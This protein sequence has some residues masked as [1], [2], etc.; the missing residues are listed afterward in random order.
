MFQYILDIHH[1][2]C[3]KTI[4]HKTTNGWNGEEKSM[5]TNFILL[6]IFYKCFSPQNVVCLLGEWSQGNID[7]IYPAV[8]YGKNS[9]NDFNFKRHEM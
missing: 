8:R 5:K 6:H 3:A 1:L 2:P 4:P 7:L 9:S